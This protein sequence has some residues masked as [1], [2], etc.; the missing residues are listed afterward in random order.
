MTSRLGRLRW[1]GLA[2]VPIAMVLNSPIVALAGLVVWWVLPSTVRRHRERAEQALLEAELIAVVDEL[3]QQVRSGSTLGA[4]F[5]SVVAKRPRAHRALGG[6]AAGVAGGRRLSESLDQLPQTQ[7]HPGEIVRLLATSLAVVSKSGGPVAPALERLAD[8]LRARR[9]AMAEATTQAS[10]AVASAV[11]LAALPV[12][13]VLVL[14]VVE[15]AA[16]SFYLTDMGGG[17]CVAA[18]LLCLVGGWVW[19]ERAIWGGTRRRKPERQ[20]TALVSVTDLVA[21]A[22]GAGGGA[23]DALRVVAERGPTPE[24]EAV[25]AMLGRWRAG[26]GLTSVLAELPDS[27]GEPYRPLASALVSAERDGAPL[28]AVLGRL[29]DE[30]RHTR[31]QLAEM[32]ARRLSVQ[33]LLPLVCCS[34]PGVVVGGVVPLVLV[35]LRR[36]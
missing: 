7:I 23:A 10:Q 2:L 29:G 33:L 32:R 18:M 9:A 6:V 22:V 27:L 25:G 26:V 21:V 11:L 1:E 28:G 3:S 4:S 20:M 8:T 31:R 14:I 15:P 13:F 30:A 16:R 36:L 19:T 17:L 35:S 5:L 34:L 24:R 12:L